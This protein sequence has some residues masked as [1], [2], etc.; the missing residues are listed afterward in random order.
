MYSGPKAN[1]TNIA[2]NWAPAL[3]LELSTLGCSSTHNNTLQNSI[4]CLHLL[5]AALHV[6]MYM[7]R[8]TTL[9]DKVCQFLGAG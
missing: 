2:P 1:L 7:E 4:G 5:K 8:C 3:E 6:L 9:C